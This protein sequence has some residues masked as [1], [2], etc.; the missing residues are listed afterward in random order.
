M[1]DTRPDPTGSA[2]GPPPGTSPATHAVDAYLDELARML[3]H[4]DP[5][6]RADVLGGVR[7]H[8]DARLAELGRPPTEAD[9]TAVLTALGPPEQVAGEASAGAPAPFAPRRKRPGTLTG[10]WVPLVTTLALF[11][12]FLGS[13][14]VLPWVVWLVGAVLLGVSTLWTVREKVLGIGLSLV[15]GIGLI[16]LLAASLLV[17]EVCTT[18]GV[19]GGETT[20]TCEGTTPVDGIV[21]V[22]IIGAVVVAA[23]VTL[24]VLLR[25][26]HAR[27][28]ALA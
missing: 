3:A 12:G 1:T 25:R 10:T 28:Q 19:E 27:A 9:V 14:L 23:G 22:A 13:A 6:E 11:L 2:A 21:L 17:A 24:V 4:A 20:T 18:I 7:E 5:V 16:A 15:A 26:G 8:V